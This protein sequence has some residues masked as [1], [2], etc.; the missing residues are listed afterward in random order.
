M[1]DDSVSMTFNKRPISSNDFLFVEGRR[2]A[3][4]VAAYDH[5]QKYAEERDRRM[6][7]SVHGYVQA[8][9]AMLSAF[10]RQLLTL[11]GYGL[12]DVKWTESTSVAAA[13]MREVRFR[14]EN[15]RHDQKYVY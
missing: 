9:R 13:V 14:A 8:C 6:K 7:G 3:R 5:M 15:R 11:D 4:I 1:C 2:L 12:L 10:N